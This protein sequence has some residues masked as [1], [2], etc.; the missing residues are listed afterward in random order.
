[1]VSALNICSIEALRSGIERQALLVVAA[2][3]TM[4]VDLL[5]DAVMARLA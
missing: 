1:M 2:C 4:A 3:P 5:L